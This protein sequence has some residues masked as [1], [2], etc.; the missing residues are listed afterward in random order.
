MN[1]TLLLDKLSSLE[2]RCQQ[3]ELDI[4]DKENMIYSLNKKIERIFLSNE[5]LFP[6]TDSKQDSSYSKEKLGVIETINSMI[7]D[8]CIKKMEEKAELIE[9]KIYQNLEQ[10]EIRIEKLEFPKQK[11]PRLQE[12]GNQ[13]E[14]IGKFEILQKKTSAKLALFESRLTKLEEGKNLK[15]SKEF[16][17]RSQSLEERG[18]EEKGREK[19]GEKVVEGQETKVKYFLFFINCYFL[20]A[21][22]YYIIYL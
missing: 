18:G 3:N 11:N 21:K 1:T 5:S 20:L 9:D 4:K 10:L 22:L 17:G 15:K 16:G 14:K 8:I 19:E 2:R 7:L 12:Q 6:P 13:G